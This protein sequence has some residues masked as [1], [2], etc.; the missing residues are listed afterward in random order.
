MTA[1]TRN[2]LSSVTAEKPASDAKD[3]AEHR[4]GE[5]RADYSEVTFEQ[6]IQPQPEL[7]EPLKNSK[8]I[9]VKREL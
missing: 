9:S 6:I 2:P 8:V 3:D 7:D 4:V 1:A 5:Y